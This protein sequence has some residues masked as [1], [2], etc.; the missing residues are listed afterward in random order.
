[1]R[2]AHPVL[3]MLG[4]MIGAFVGMF[5][6]TA[7]NIA[8]PSLMA[9]LH[10]GQGTIQWLV[11]GYMLVIGIC[12][13]LSSLL[14]HRFATKKI[15]LVALGAF[16]IGAIVSATAGTFA[17][18]LI[19]RMIQGIGTG[20]VLPLMF[21]V[22][23]Q[24]F[25][26]HKLGT[27]MGMAALVIMFAPA[28]GPTLTGLLLAKASW[29]AIFWLF[30]PLL[31]IAFALCAVALETVYPQTATAIDWGS[32]TL[33]TLGFGGLVIGVSFAS[34]R[35]WL[36][37]P[38]LLALLVGIVALGLFARRQLRLPQPMLNLRAFNTR[39]FTVGTLLVML[40]FGLILAAMYL[41]PT[42]LQTTMKLPV[43]M[44][45]LV[46]LPGGVV[47]ALVSAIA[48]RSYDRYGAKWLT[49]CG[50]VIAILGI[51]VLLNTNAN[52][53]IGTVIAGHVIL[54]IGAPLAMSPAQTY[55]LNALSGAMSADG[56]AILNTLQQIVGA[57]ATAIATSMLALGLGQ[58]A[59]LA[60]HTLGAHYG[61][62][63]VLVIAVIA[64]AV[65]FAVRPTTRH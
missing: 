18:V 19:G 65:S 12:M 29:H 52:S 20:L 61:F 36:A 48:G 5:S 51:V 16:I 10:V 34:D 38:V 13:P 60:G 49:R 39:A 11:T 4:L 41:L 50:F 42:Y 64:L 55:G 63:F 45:G 28:I 9:A 17:G 58:R 37:W 56:S 21:S 7:L 25:P 6:E 27:V 24:I 15:V 43:A 32:I 23:L 2:L 57:C 40:D 22:A 26:P 1:M 35:G 46:M 47:N 8:L 62:Q 3:A 33:S 31:A 59:G 14:A 30:V 44:T 53:A 54:M